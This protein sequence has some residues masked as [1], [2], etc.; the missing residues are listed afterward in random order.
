MKVFAVNKPGGSS[1]KS[2]IRSKFRN[3]K[4]RLGTGRPTEASRNNINAV[5]RATFFDELG[6]SITVPL[7]HPKNPRSVQRFPE[8]GKR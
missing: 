6:G 1:S 7:Y 4:V 5:R 2:A 3:G 8:F